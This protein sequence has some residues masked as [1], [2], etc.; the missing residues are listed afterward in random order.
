[1]ADIYNDTLQESENLSVEENPFRSAIRT[2]P[3]I[4]I[5]L[6]GVVQELKESYSKTALHTTLDMRTD[7][8][9]LVHNGFIY[10]AADYAALAA[11]N[12]PFSVSI[13]SRIAFFAPVKVG[14]VV[15]F[16]AHSHFD[17]SRKKE[18]RVTGKVKD[19]KIFEGTFQIVVL[20]DHIFKV[21]SKQKNKKP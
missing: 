21:Q 5:N 13:G 14:E 9:G 7:S 12:Q 3:D 16:E 8:D 19:I 17:E 4:N 1:M 2:S 11:V 18:V 20:E 10:G 6:C 15:E